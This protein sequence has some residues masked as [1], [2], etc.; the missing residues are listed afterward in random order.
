MNK[1]KKKRDFQFLKE[2]NI[3]KQGFGA[4]FKRFMQ[5]KV[6]DLLG[7]ENAVHQNIHQYLKTEADSKGISKYHIVVKIVM[8]HEGLKVFIYYRGDGFREATVKELVHFFM[9][10]LAV[11]EKNVYEK[12]ADSVQRFLE[13]YAAYQGVALYNLAL[14]ISLKKDDTALVK[15]FH[16]AE[17]MEELSVP[18]LIEYFRS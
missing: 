9:G 7:Y 12:T 8:T 15:S 13:E 6:V 14:L 3:A 17:M 2:E 10:A 5:R 11:K 18:F 16:H 1:Q 4:K